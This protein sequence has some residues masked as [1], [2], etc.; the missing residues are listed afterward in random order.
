MRTLFHDHFEQAG[1]R[2]C[3]HKTVPIIRRSVNVFLILLLGA[4][5]GWVVLDVLED[6]R[7]DGSVFKVIAGY[8]RC[9]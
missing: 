7:L 1:C 3:G 5:L 9:W 4:L 8:S 6:G 2:V